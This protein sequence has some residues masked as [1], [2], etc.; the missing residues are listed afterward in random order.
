MYSK[1]RSTQTLL[2]SGYTRLVA[3]MNS[4]NAFRDLKDIKLY[5][6]VGAK[7]P[8]AQLR[9]NFGQKPFLFDIDGM[10]AVRLS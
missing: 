10:M 6:S 5:P 4:G 2:S 7:R 3:D 8:G 9:V 1:V